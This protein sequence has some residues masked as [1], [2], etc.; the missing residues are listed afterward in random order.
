MKNSKKWL[1]DLYMFYLD[2]YAKVNN[3]H[4]IN[5]L[6]KSNLG[7]LKATQSLTNLLN[8]TASLQVRFTIHNLWV[9]SQDSIDIINLFFRRPMKEQVIICFILSRWILWKITNVIIKKI[10]NGWSLI[11]FATNS[12]PT[13]ATLNTQKF[14][15]SWVLGKGSVTL[16]KSY[17]G[18]F[19]GEKV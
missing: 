4:T 2:F 16:T 14:N 12:Q 15:S 3:S 13:I 19:V 17:S 9:L 7:S 5:S 10:I 18:N 8:L 1:Q 11:S 6:I